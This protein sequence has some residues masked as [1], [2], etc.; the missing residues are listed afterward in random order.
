MPSEGGK[1]AFFK[2]RNAILN[3]LHVAYRV[4][5]I[6]LNTL[7]PSPVRRVGEGKYADVFEVALWTFGKSIEPA[8][9]MPTAGVVAV[10]ILK[11]EKIDQL[12]ALPE[13]PSSRKAKRDDRQKRYQEKVQRRAVK[14]L[15]YYKRECVVWQRCSGDPAKARENN[16]VELLGLVESYQNSRLPVFVSRFIS[17]GSVHSYIK[18]RSKPSLSDKDRILIISDVAKALA[19]LHNIGTVH[20]DIKARNVLIERTEERY[21]GLLADFGASKVLEEVFLQTASSTISQDRWSPPEYLLE[22]SA[23]HEETGGGDIWALGCTFL[24]VL[25]EQEP[26]Q[27]YPSETYKVLL[28]D[29]RHPVAGESV[30]LE[31]KLRF[32]HVEDKCYDIMK[33]CWTEERQNRIAAGGLYLELR[34]L[35]ETC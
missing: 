14:L 24:E 28:C 7:H 10:K 26:W 23:Q 15:E 8:Q 3:E 6:E 12:M 34:R 17:E 20:R 9:E 5:R 21:I 29:Y 18:D 30:D 33:K 1:E 27:P 31:S 2:A 22:V 32:R 11:E 35:A 4:P 16:F 13:I 25:Q 19:F